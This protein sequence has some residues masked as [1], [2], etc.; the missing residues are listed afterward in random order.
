MNREERIGNLGT[1]MQL[2]IMG[3]N[4]E[5]ERCTEKELHI[6]VERRD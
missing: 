2:D 1:P 4:T 6:S 5:E 3:Q